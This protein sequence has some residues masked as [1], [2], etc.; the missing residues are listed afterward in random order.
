MQNNTWV[1]SFYV[2]PFFVPVIDCLDLFIVVFRRTS[3]KGHGAV[4]IFLLRIV[5]CSNV[6]YALTRVGH[7]TV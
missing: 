7:L 6:R 2:R 3:L 4:I 1:E 5:P